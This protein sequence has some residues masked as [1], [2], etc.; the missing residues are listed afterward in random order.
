MLGDELRGARLVAKWRQE[1]LADEAGISRN[2]VS[3]LKPDRK[4]TIP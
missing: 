1:K 3:L 2:Y 4:V